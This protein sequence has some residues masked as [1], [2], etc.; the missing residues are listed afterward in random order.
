M[1]LLHTLMKA[2]GHMPILLLLPTGRPDGVTYCPKSPPLVPGAPKSAGRWVVTRV[3]CYKTL[4]KMSDPRAAGCECPLLM[5]RGYTNHAGVGCL[6]T[7][8]RNS[9]CHRPKF[10]AGVIVRAKVISTTTTSGL[11]SALTY[12]RLPT[13][14]RVSS[15]S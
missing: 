10:D 3:R 13:G 11:V 14:T 2:D 9:C 4:H 5:V 15:A 1:Q 6:I 8:H 12:R 7:Q